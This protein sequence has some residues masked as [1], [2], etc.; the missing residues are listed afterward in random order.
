MPAARE[1]TAATTVQRWW[2]RCIAGTAAAQQRLVH[3]LDLTAKISDSRT[4]DGFVVNITSEQETL[5]IADHRYGVICLQRLG[6]DSDQFLNLKVSQGRRLF[7]EEEDQQPVKVKCSVINID[8]SG[9]SA[10]MYP[11]QH[12]VHDLKED[13]NSHPE[14]AFVKGETMIFPDPTDEWTISV[15]GPNV[16]EKKMRRETF[17][18]IISFGKKGLRSDEKKKF[19]LPS[20]YTKEDVIKRAIALMEHEMEERAATPGVHDS[21]GNTQT[22]PHIVNIVLAIHVVFH[23]NA[24]IAAAVAGGAPSNHQ[25]EVHQ[26]QEEVHQQQEE[27]LSTRVARVRNSRVS[28]I[29]EV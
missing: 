10:I 6:P 2:R 15:T 12:H 1:C 13:K 17:Y 22:R 25:E 23:R 4:H 27:I 29:S 5:P 16:H 20:N 19:E 18:V 3:F 14:K 24:I 8:E 28:Y 11:N 26:Q 21:D 7:P 9:Q